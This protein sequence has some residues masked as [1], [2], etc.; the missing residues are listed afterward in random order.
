MAQ[1][2]TFDIARFCAEMERYLGPQE[3][4]AKLFWQ[5]LS[6]A[7]SAHE[8]QR[9]KSGEA[10]VSHPCAVARI[11]VREMEVRDP[12][13]LAAAALHDT[14]EDV[15]EVTNEVIGEIFGKHV[16]EIVDGCTKISN[17][18]GS[19]QAFYKIVHRKIFSGAAS[20]ME[21]MVI[22]LALSLDGR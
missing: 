16:E 11:L 2:K 9:R 4:K 17:F 1:P 12:Q 3:G 6:F 8:G 19:K 22:K 20:H 13:I 21:V 10:Y 15:A 5:A 18:E 7:V 14:V